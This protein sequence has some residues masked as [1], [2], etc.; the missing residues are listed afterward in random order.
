MDIGWTDFHNPLELA[1]YYK[2]VL[3]SSG[4]KA[5]D[6]VRLF[7]LC[8]NN[9]GLREENLMSTSKHTKTQIIA[10]LKQVEAGR[11]VKD[12][13]REH[14]V[15]KFTVY[16]W[17]TKYSALEVNEAQRLSQLAEENSRLKRLVADLSLER[18]TLK[19]VIA[20]SGQSLYSERRMDAGSK[21]SMSSVSPG[22]AA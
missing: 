11:K 22:R 4:P 21:S 12:V 9:V 1:D 18:E 7:L 6:S 10:A 13:A 5:T 8:G 14:G 20:R 19:A 15:S 17:K 2:A 16:A 3:K